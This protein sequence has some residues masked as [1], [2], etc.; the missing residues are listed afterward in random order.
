MKKTT[1]FLCILLTSA[2]AFG[3]EKKVKQEK[4]FGITLQMNSPSKDDV[5][6]GWYNIDFESI[7]DY[8]LKHN[9][10]AGGLLVNY[11]INDET[12]LRLRYGM[13]KYSIEEYK[14]KYQSGIFFVES[15]KGEQTKMQFAPGITWK[16]NK[17]KFSIFGGFELPINLHGEFS[18]NYVY[19]NTD[20]LTGKTT[21]EGQL[22]IN[23]P[24][25]YSIG[26]GAIMG[27]NYFPAK[28]FS[29]GAEYSPSLLYAKLSGQTK[30]VTTSIYPSLPTTTDYTED[31][32]KGFTFYEQRFS[33]NLTVWF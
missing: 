19:K 9:S 5:S 30:S 13:T 22:L 10:F 4:K 31:E 12:T 18:M 27:F 24:K 14:N 21:R 7:D 15:N 28:H 32:E 26:V 2:F 20:S 6:L 1:I 33:I 3:Q 17:N 29:I 23:I 16:M 8:K 25:G 11:N